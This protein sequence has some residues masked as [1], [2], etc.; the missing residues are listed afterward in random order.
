LLPGGKV[1]VAGGI[2][3]SWLFLRSAELYD[4]ATERW[5]ATGDMI[6]ARPLF[7]ATLLHN[8]KVLVAA[9]VRDEPYD[10]YGYGIEKAELY[11]PDT[12]QWSVTG[13]LTQPR[14]LNSMTLL[15]N[16]MVLVAGGYDIAANGVELYDPATGRWSVTGNLNTARSDHTA[17]LLANG[18]VLVAGGTSSSPNSAEL[19]DPGFEIPLLTLN[20]TSYCIG[21][22]WNL[23]VSSSAANTL[24]RLL[25]TSD[26]A[27]WEV[28]NWQ[29]TDANGNVDE[30][31]TFA[32]GTEGTHSLRV[33]IGGRFSNA[34]SFDVSH[35]PIQIALNSSEYCTGASWTLKLDSDF[36]NAWMSLSGT[37]NNEPWEIAN[38]R[39]TGVDGKL[40]EA[41]TFLPGS[42]GAH[43]LRARIGAAQS[44]LFSFRVSRCGQ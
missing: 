41:G 43:S 21:A 38:W 27:P 23:R 24:I 6:T 25:G 20:S 9:G 12:G 44:D 19:Y 11:D 28:P 3:T 29:K 37:S 35:C 42:E 40:T 2:N 15:S 8:G 39:A 4:P 22:S 26:D 13:S 32:T 1:L 33:D 5:T 14:A 18:K 16:G 10:H 36:P 7:V 31:G 30:T 34:V 17:T